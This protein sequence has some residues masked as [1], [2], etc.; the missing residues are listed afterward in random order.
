MLLADGQTV[1]GYAKIATVIGADL[2]RLGRLLPGD[3]LRFALVDADTAAAARRASDAWLAAQIAAIRT[4]PPTG[5][6][7]LDALYTHNLVDGVIHAK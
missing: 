1:G 5:G 6:I 2:P 4:L 3:E 7:D